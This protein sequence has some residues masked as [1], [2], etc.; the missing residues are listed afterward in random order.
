MSGRLGAPQRSRG[1]NTQQRNPRHD[2]DGDLPPLLLKTPAPTP[3]PTPPDDLE[4]LLAT[5]PVPQAPQA[6][7]VLQAP[8]LLP[9]PETRLGDLQNAPTVLPGTNVNYLM[10][11][12][13][14]QSKQY[15]FCNTQMNTVS[16]TTK[17]HAIVESIESMT[18]DYPELTPGPTGSFNDFFTLSDQLRRVV[19]E[20]AGDIYTQYDEPP[21][22][23]LRRSV[24]Q[25]DYTDTPGSVWT[26]LW[27]ALIANAAGI[28]PKIF[29]GGL[30]SSGRA[31]LLM[32]H[33]KLGSL[34][35]FLL[36]H[37]EQYDTGR[38]Y[39]PSLKQLL[40]KSGRLGMV[41]GDIKPGNIIVMT[42][43]ELQ[44]IDFDPKFTVLLEADTFDHKCVEFINTFLLLS[45]MM[46]HAKGSTV[47]G[48]EEDLIDTLKMGYSMLN[49]G[50][51]GGL[52]GILGRLLKNDRRLIS[53]ND[54]T[55][56][57]DLVAKHVLF[58]AGEYLG[59][60]QGG[61]DRGCLIPWK[62]ED[63]KPIIVQITDAALRV[64]ETR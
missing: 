6:Q 36:I 16:Y 27:Y 44:F 42:D 35:S 50:V 3:T 4:A 45:Q 64:H 49:G 28:G 37:P 47:R 54:T 12:E 21:S 39:S 31:V 15:A 43:T 9:P 46:C 40:A 7:Q 51:G 61:V 25:R 63:R 20:A 53:K 19:T 55:S 62:F 8:P 48:L 24:V 1:A 59:W 5:G 18:H 41:L 30:T 26:E 2:G 11:L 14:Y 56:R 17:L 33:G 32:E 29:A 57:M 23:G 52:C 22:V 10:G 34:D 60:W 58:M 13:L 38:A